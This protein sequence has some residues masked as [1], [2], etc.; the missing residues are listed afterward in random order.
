VSE[1]E[2]VALREALLERAG[3]AAARLATVE[4]LE[5][6][7]G[8]MMRGA[9][10]E[11]PDVVLTETAFMGHLGERLAD[12]PDPV[13][14]LRSTR[15]A[16]LYLACACARGDERAVAALERR[17][18]PEVDAHLASTAVVRGFEDEVKQRLRERLLVA[19]GAQAPRIAG[20]GGR[21]PLG[22]WICVAAARI[23]LNLRRDERLA[24]QED[25]DPQVLADGRVDP[26]IAYLKAR[27]GA[28]VEEALRQAMATLDA[29]QANLLRMHFVEGVTATAI[30]RM[31]RTTRRTIHRWVADARAKVLQETR[32][33]L[34]ERLH[35]G[36]AEFESLFGFVESRIDVSIHD[37]LDPKAK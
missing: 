27:Y 37:V 11:W 9:R 1:K 7:L 12:E 24:G 25:R 26:E 6:Q 19:E 8:G 2:T 5:E 15:A 20:Y 34:A 22:A 16:D 28:E 31:Y 4:D 13:S 29:R 3:A 21:G 36:G 10:T 33:L 17:F 14:A 18:M 35:L 32:R 30:A 23:A